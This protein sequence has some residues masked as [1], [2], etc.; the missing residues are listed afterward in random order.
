MTYVFRTHRPY[1][2]HACDGL[3]AFNHIKIGDWEIY[4]CDVCSEIIIYRVSNRV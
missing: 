3:K 4:L 2:C 1:I